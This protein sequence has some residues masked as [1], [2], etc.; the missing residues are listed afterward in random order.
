MSAR[1]EMI[2]RHAS[3]LALGSAQF[4]MRYGIANSD[5]RPA[6]SVVDQIVRKA[7]DSAISVIDTAYAYGDSE[8]VLGRILSRDRNVRI[9]TKTP[10]IW[11]EQISPV[12]I[13]SVNAAFD[14]SLKR[15]C[16]SK[17]YGLLIHN[18][19]DLLKSGGD[20]LWNWLESAK[21]DGRA[22][23][24]GVSVNSPEQLDRLLSC[25][26]GIELVQLPLNIYDQRFAR[27]GLLGF[28]RL[29]HIEAHARSAFLQG[30]LLMA[31]ERLPDQFSAIRQHQA[32][33]HQWLR[34]RGFSPL[35]G[36]LSAAI[37]NP[38]VDVVVV[39]CE[40]LRQ[41]QEIITAAS[42]ARA[43]DLDRFAIADENIINPSRWV[44]P[45]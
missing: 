38:N 20:R 44:I 16:R 28:L 4:G 11:N 13:E 29:E 2:G 40:S 25:Y 31:P 3:R 22:E 18:A 43:C 17:V 23:K 9:V 10:R 36:A 15:L 45:N 7:R 6:C 33:L 24:I 35:A 27:S 19:D 21:A 32:D 37:S 12:D 39:G 14:A 5:G 8:T 26:R 41:L 42:D 1:H 34:T 30:L